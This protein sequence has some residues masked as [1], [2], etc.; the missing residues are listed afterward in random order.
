[1]SIVIG[2]EKDWDKYERT[3][4]DKGICP[5]CKE[6]NKWRLPT[7]HELKSIFY[8]SKNKPTTNMEGIKIDRYWTSTPDALDSTNKWCFDFY[9]GHTYRSHKRSIY[10]VWC[11]R[12]LGDGS[13]EWAK[14]DAPTKM[15]WDEAME[16][17]ESMNEAKE[18]TISE[19]EN[20]LGYKIKI[21]KE[22]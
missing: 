1:M 21:V 12:T 2:E 15:T 9:Y 11:V 16:Y 4:H 13:L 22:K 14:E 17:A 7:I 5:H 8:Y 6:M 20:M 3:L 19:I 10:H 18:I